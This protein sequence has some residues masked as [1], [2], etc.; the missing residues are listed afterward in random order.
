MHR[1]EITLSLHALSLTRT[2][3]QRD[4]TKFHLLMAMST[5]TTTLVMEG[6][7]VYLY[8]VWLDVHSNVF[9]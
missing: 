8:V 4:V 5:L 9:A 3:V 2:D 1:L 6:K 7:R